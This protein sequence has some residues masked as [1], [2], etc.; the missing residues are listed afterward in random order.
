MHVMLDSTIISI[1]KIQLLA[2]FFFSG[3]FRR[4]FFD[5][6]FAIRV[7]RKFH[8][9]HLWGNIPLAA[10]AKKIIFSSPRTFKTKT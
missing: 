3:G 7:H 10:S 8:R 9:T 1:G 6:V 5:E 4:N 2:P